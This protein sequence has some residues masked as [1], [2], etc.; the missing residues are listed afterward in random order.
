MTPRQLTPKVVNITGHEG[1]VWRLW[2][3]GGIRLVECPLNHF[4][5]D[6]WPLK[7]DH[8]RKWIA[9]GDIALVEQSFASGD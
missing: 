4:T 6:G 9:S 7:I 8:V 2:M 1:L 5:H 3:H